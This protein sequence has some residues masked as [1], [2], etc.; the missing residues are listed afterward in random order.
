VVNA[1]YTAEE[2][3]AF[4]ER[5]SDHIELKTGT[6]NRPLQEALVA[7]SN[8]DGGAILVG[9]SNDRQVA[10]RRLDQGTED[11]IHQAARDAHSVGRYSIRQIKVAGRPVVAIEVSRREEG[12]AQTSEGRLLVRRGGSN[13]AL[14]GADAWDFMSQRALRRFEQMDSQVPLANADQ[15]ALIELCEAYAWDASDPKLADRLQERHLAT[16][17]ATLT[18]AGAL[19]LTDPSASVGLA[20]AVVEI[21]RYPDDGTD[22]DRRV[23]FGGPL[24]QQVRDATLFV[25]D[26]L[27]SDLVVAGLYRYDLP[28]LPEVVV[29]EALANAVAHRSYEVD[30]AS[31]LVEM[32]PD[33]LA[34]TSPGSLPEP[35]TVSTMRQAQAARNPSVIDVLRR[36]SLAEDAGRGVDVMQDTMEE[37]LLDP[38][39]FAEEAASV[40]VTLPL[41]GPI[42]PRERAWVAD[43]ERRGQLMV[44][45]RL[46]LVYAAR[47]ERLTNRRAREILGADSTAARN[48]LHRLR[49]S[50]L[51]VQ[52][53]Q[54]GGAMYTLTESVAPPAAFRM[55]PRQLENLVLAEAQHGPLSNADVRRF[56]GLDRSDTLAL[57]QKLVAEGGLIQTGERRG[58]RYVLRR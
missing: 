3:A 40:I 55:T 12:F 58:T 48:A 39:A 20:K 15:G 4:I 57:L 43:L 38:P 26:E 47:G 10:G 33:R 42:T 53:G 30:R 31:I 25:M 45:D 37:A 14:I 49:D 17:A 1:S 5:E 35:V 41:R 50:G 52:H 32:R 11:S 56:T 46:L 22:Y 51:L 9:V 34:I 44:T 21:R 23:F 19:F 24:Q 2:F 29:R 28:R 16:S 36:F 13:I 18:I 54:R 8:A 27:G 7:L 6:G